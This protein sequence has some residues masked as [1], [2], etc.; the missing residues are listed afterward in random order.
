M[1]WVQPSKKKEEKDAVYIYK[2]EYHS[3]IKNNKIISFAATGMDLEIIMLSEISQ[4][5]KDNN[6]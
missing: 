5:E 1:P 2:M 3:A 6:K 4:K